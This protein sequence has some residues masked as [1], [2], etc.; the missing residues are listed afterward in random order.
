MPVEIDFY[1][2]QAPLLLGSP[3]YMP[4]EQ[5]VHDLD[6]DIRSDFYSLGAT[7]Y[8]CLT[9]MPPYTGEVQE[10]FQKHLSEDVPSVLLCNSEIPEEVSN[11][12]IALMQKSP[13]DRP[14]NAKLLE[15]Y[16]EYMLFQNLYYQNRLDENI[17]YNI[18]NKMQASFQD[19]QFIQ[20][21]LEQLAL[22]NQQ[23]D[24]NAEQNLINEY[25]QNIMT[26]YSTN[27]SKLKTIHLF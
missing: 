11:L 5:I 4:P 27:P 7:F 21:T 16:L 3:L 9:G 23:P 10:V 14:K 24:E 8:H 18:V 13:Q 26:L 15:T 19:K 22:L 20:Y 1:D 25:M 12:I 17:E 2:P 6:L